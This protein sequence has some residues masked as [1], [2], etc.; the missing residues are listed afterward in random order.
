MKILN[1]FSRVLSQIQKHH[2]GS[3]LEVLKYPL[4][5]HPYGR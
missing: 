2:W 4:G 5:Y 3:V 1:N